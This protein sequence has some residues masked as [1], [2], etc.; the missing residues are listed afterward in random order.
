MSVPGDGGF[1]EIDENLLGFEIL[2]E[3]PRA[4]F[5]AKAGLFVAAPGR[6]DVRR[7]HVIDPNDAGAERFYDAESFVDVAGPD[8]SGE[9]VGR[10]IGDANGFR[11]AVERNDGS[12]GPEDFFASD[13]RGVFHVVENRGLD[14]VALAE[15][16]GAAAADGNFGFLFADVE[17]GADAVVLFFADQRTH[18][19]VAFQRRAELDA[20]GFFG[21]GFDELGI[22]LFLHKDAAARG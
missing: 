20:L 9:A 2:F 12:D 7:L 4:K 13:A 11:F 15:L 14:V 10:V 21:H 1:V 6:F 17:V 8:G 5:A 16:L 18:F 3:A 19:G 22:D